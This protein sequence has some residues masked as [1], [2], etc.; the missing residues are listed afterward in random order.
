MERGPCEKC[1]KEHR[2]W[3]EVEAN[4]DGLRAVDEVIRRWVGWAERQI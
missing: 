2:E 3:F 1:G 4:R